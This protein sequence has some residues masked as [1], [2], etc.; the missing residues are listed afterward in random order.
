MAFR[1]GYIGLGSLGSAIYP[2]L[3]AYSSSN[4]LPA[5]SVWNRSQD[6]YAD[7]KAQH[8]DILTAKEITEL[9]DR[10]NVI[11]TCLV[12]DAAVEDVYLKLVAALKGS[13]EK[14]TFVDQSTVKVST[15]GEYWRRGPGY[16]KSS[17]MLFLDKIK[18]L[19]EETGSKY[20]TCPVFGQPPAARNRQ[21]ICV[22]SGDAQGREFIKPLLAAIGRYTIDVGEDNGKGKSTNRNDHFLTEYH[23][24]G[25]ALKLLG[26]TILL[27]A[28]QLY[29]ETYALAD[30]IDFDPMVFH[31]LHR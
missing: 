27:G 20:L 25:A 9:V 5:L 16:D 12:D 2:N 14:V 10:C 29:A 3:Q 7:I 11:F 18:K 19:V 15:A 1:I 13:K 21:L 28:I 8:P 4:S 23:R 26:N 22:N 31:E 24:I 17:L 6:K 30:A